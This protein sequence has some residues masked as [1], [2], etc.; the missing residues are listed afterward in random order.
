[1]SQHFV[2]GVLVVNLETYFA[3]LILLAAL[4][5][6]RAW[7]LLILK[8]F[9]FSDVG[10]FFSIVNAL[11]LS[12]IAAL[13]SALNHGLWCLRGKV[14]DFGMHDSAIEINLLVKDSIS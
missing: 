7:A 11:F 6:F 13:Q 5:I 4:I 2:T 9:R 12:L 14:D 10:C 1:M 8:A 3:Q